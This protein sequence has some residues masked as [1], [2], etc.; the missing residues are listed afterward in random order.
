MLTFSFFTAVFLTISWL[1]YIGTYIFS[2][3]GGVSPAAL[4]LTD[5]AVYTALAVVPLFVIWMTW[6]GFY[7]FRHEKNLQKQFKNIEAQFKQNQEFFEIVARMLWQG[8]QNRQNHFVLERTELF[9]SELNGLLADMLQRYNFISDSEAAKLWSTA[10]KGNKWGF[11]KALISLQNSS[12]DFEN[13]LYRAAVR[14]TLVKAVPK[15]GAFVE[16]PAGYGTV[17]Q[18]NLLRGTVNEFCARYARLLELLKMHDQ[19]KI[20]LPVIETGALGKAFA[21][22][23][24]LADRLQQ[25]QPAAPK[26]A[27]EP[28]LFADAEMRIAPA[29]ERADDE[30]ADNEEDPLA[31]LEELS[32]T[33]IFGE[34][35]NDGEERQPAAEPD[36]AAAAGKNEA[37]GESTAGKEEKPN[38]LAAAE[39]DTE[40]APEPVSVPAE[41][42]A[43]ETPAAG[44]DA[45]TAKIEDEI[46]RMFAGAGVRG[47]DEDEDDR[48]ATDKAPFFPKFS[49]LFKRKPAKE[50]PRQPET[51]I[52][53]LTLALERS[54]GKL[55]DDAPNTG[56]RLYKMMNENA[57][58]NAEKEDAAGNKFA[59]ASTNETIMK[60]QEE[61][62]KLKNSD[63]G[64]KENGKSENGEKQNG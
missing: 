36:H 21:I 16:T 26:T 60:L 52:D 56:S 44:K 43:A 58:E 6:N 12:V 37:N 35:I 20:F 33:E 14:E 38:V 50:Q 9:V 28:E 49:N 40:T 11:A 17:I 31:E 34:E 29:A 47:E 46:S 2:R 18:V 24:P 25:N 57:E 39:T 41:E 10:E 1:M 27:D 61:L 13:R 4:G 19:E 32:L 15:N 45:A 30:I 42:T 63:D 51:E 64:E 7:R 3:L 59:F 8:Q 48:K 5:L 22:L 54:F 55:A 62:E 23:A 53:P